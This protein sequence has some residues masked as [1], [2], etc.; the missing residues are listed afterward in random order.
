VKVLLLSLPGFDESDGCMFPLGI[1]YLASSL[2][3]SNDV[4]AL[5]FQKMRTAYEGV[6]EALREFK[7]ALVGISC[8][9][10]NRAFVRGM[11]RRVKK[12]SPQT[13]VVTGGVHASFCPDH[14]LLG[15]GAD[16]VVSGEGE[17]TLSELCATL[18]KGGSLSE[19]KGI[20]YKVGGELK[21]TPP[22]P[23]ITDLDS[24]PMPDFSYAEDLIKRSGVG[25]I[26]ASRGCPVCCSFCSTSSFWG[27]K[28]RMSSPM[29]VVDEMQAL[30]ANYGVKKIF[31]HDDTFNL[32]VARV[33]EICAEIKRRGLNVEWSCSC[34]VA[35]VSYEMLS[36]MVDAGCSHICWGVESG[37]PEIL[38]R[39]GKKITPEHIR[40]AFELSAKFGEALS[41]GAFAMVGN[42]GETSKTIAETL[43]LLNSVPITDSPS[44][45][46][47]YVLPG[48]SLC[49]KLMAEGLL[50][51]DDWLRYDSIP[52]YTLENSF[53][54]LKRWNSLVANSGRVRPFDRSK[55]F[56]ADAV[57][58]A[59]P[60]SRRTRSLK[61]LASLWNPSLLV[62][63]VKKL[64]PAGRIRFM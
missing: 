55:H 31:F 35:P 45:A 53:L 6:E 3:S 51:H 39:I 59:A 36:A 60:E 38:A 26:I 25:F 50:K 7:P 12:A 52:C 22:R 49:D 62:S 29:R 14:M 58:G 48:T 8:T 20:A 27:Q 56:W 44:T 33:L 21:R 42:P 1:A 2:K 24:L 23:P 57:L 43:A 10:F 17:S 11:I 54:T 32:G 28:V 47:L 40:N 30:V 9:S 13:I 5:H 19:V 18:E 41:T 15:Y 61:K 64:L 4:M 34:R 46:S 63:R 16:I 37:S